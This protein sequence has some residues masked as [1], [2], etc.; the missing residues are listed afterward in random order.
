MNIK[1]LNE[2]LKKLL[3]SNISEFFDE[4][5]AKFSSDKLRYI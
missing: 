4:V 3:E 2:A 1:Q 5:K